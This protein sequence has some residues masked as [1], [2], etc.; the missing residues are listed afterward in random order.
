MYGKR[1]VRASITVWFVVA[2]YTIVL[3]STVWEADVVLRRAFLKVCLLQDDASL[4]NLLGFVLP[5][6][7]LVVIHPE[8]VE[9]E[10]EEGVEEEEPVVVSCRGNVRLRLLV[11]QPSL[12]F[13][14]ESQLLL[15][16][17]TGWVGG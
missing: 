1:E 11:F 4:T 2:S 14:T 9:E 5:W 13:W 17:G 10:E 7:F 12:R 6:E 15:M 8:D 16:V 3:G